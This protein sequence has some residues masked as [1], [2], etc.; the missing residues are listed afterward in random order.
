M[1]GHEGSIVL[2]ITPLVAFMM[3]QKQRFADRGIAVEY[4]GEAQ[5][6]DDAVVAVTSGKVQLVYISPE[7]ILNHLHFRN[8]LFSN[9]YKEKLVTLAVDEAHC[10]KM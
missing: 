7:N 10:I 9:V 6:D 2:V 5:T 8:M 4:V 3:D 1:L